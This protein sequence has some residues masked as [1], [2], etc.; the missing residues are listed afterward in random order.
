MKLKKFTL[1]ELLVVIAIIAI[2]AAILLPALQKA[3][4]KARSTTCLNNVKQC[5]IVFRTYEDANDGFLPAAYDGSNTWLSFMG[6][7]MKMVA[8]AGWTATDGYTVKRQFYLAGAWGCPE[9]QR[10]T[11]GARYAY[12]TYAFSY[13][14]SHGIGTASMGYGYNGHSVIQKQP[15]KPGKIRR[16]GNVA[17]IMDGYHYTITSCADSNPQSPALRH[18]NGNSLNILFLDGHADTWIGALPD[19]YSSPDNKKYPWSDVL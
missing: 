13:A 17:L 8:K 16:P 6:E 14:F 10:M 11:P 7:T 2:L 12:P 1:I 9:D 15:S 3:R 19:C 5:F 4:A 18:D